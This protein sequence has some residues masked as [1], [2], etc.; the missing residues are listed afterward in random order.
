MHH[1]RKQGASGG[2]DDI[3]DM[4]DFDHGVRIAGEVK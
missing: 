1:A 3:A 2:T 4:Q